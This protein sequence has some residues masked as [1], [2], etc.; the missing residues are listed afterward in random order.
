MVEDLRGKLT[1]VYGEPDAVTNNLDDVL[2]KMI[3][4]EFAKSYYNEEVAKCA[5]TYVV[6]KSTANNA[7]VVLKNYMENGDWQRVKID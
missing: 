1:Q 6:W 2:G 4:D 5:P 7:A 3:F